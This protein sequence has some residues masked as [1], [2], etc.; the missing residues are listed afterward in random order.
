MVTKQE[1]YDI[2]RKLIQKEVDLAFFNASDAKLIRIIEEQVRVAIAN[3]EL[4]KLIGR[5][6]KDYIESNLKEVIEIVVEKH[7]NYVNSKL[8]KEYK[9][10]KDLSYSIHAEIKHTLMKTPISYNAEQEM[11]NVIMGELQ[12]VKIKN[13][14]LENASDNSSQCVH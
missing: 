9:I 1:V 2:V 11:I 5:I 10:A 4:H 14:Q 6:V 8:N 12:K 7:V 13:K 3:T